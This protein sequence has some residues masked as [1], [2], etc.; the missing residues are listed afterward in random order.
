M[1][2]G[3]G[4]PLLLA[5]L[6]WHCESQEVMGSEGFF[7]AGASLDGSFAEWDGGAV[8]CFRVMRAIAP[9]AVYA[10]QVHPGHGG[11]ECASGAQGPQQLL[12]GSWMS[13]SVSLWIRSAFLLPS[14]ARR[15]YQS[16]HTAK[17][18]SSWIAGQAKC[19]TA[20]SV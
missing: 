17:V 16:T 1:V 20:F 2:R 18:F 6:I 8:G 12:L 15:V 19:G 14:G 10:Q 5:E 9:N 3:L 7:E 4:A 11:H 13:A